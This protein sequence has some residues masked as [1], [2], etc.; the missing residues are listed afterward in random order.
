[1]PKYKS[2]CPVTPLSRTSH[3]DSGYQAES[4]EKIKDT[5]L[6]KE[7]DMLKVDFPT[8]DSSDDTFWFI[9]VPR[10]AMMVVMMASLCYMVL[11]PDHRDMV[12]VEEGWARVKLGGKRAAIQFYHDSQVGL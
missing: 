8:V 9:T 4:V 5:F 10:I 2:K 1:M 3:D 12:E 11:M 6:G 7:K